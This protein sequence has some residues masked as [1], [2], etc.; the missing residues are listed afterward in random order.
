MYT[1]KSTWSITLVSGTVKGHWCHFIYH[2]VV[3]HMPLGGAGPTSRLPTT[4][5]PGSS[6]HRVFKKSFLAIKN[7]A[8]LKYSPFFFN[9]R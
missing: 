1:R 4:A 8:I 3:I 2:S 9:T 6:V 5:F 7:T